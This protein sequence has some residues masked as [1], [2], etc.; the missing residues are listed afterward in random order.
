MK[1]LLIAIGL[2]VA[3][4]ALAHAQSNSAPA[5]KRDCHEAMNDMAGKDMDHSKMDHSKMSHSGMDHSKM[6]HSAM[7][8]SKMDHAA[9]GKGAKPGADAHAG[10]DM[11]KADKAGSPAPAAG[12]QH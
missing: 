1:N 10:H 6:D 11:S 3:L 7:D 5:S 4:P 9:M 2:S 12:H 8:H